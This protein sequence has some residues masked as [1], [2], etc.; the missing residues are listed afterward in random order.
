MLGEI[1]W[2]QY[3]IAFIIACHGISYIL[4]GIIVSSRLQGWKGGSWILGGRVSGDRLKS[5]VLVPH[6]AA[7]ALIIA[8]GVAIG[9]AASLPGWWR[10]VAIV[11][12]ALGLAGFAAFL[13][14]KPQLGVREGGIGAGI[15][16][17]LLVSAIVFA[18]AFR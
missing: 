4:F 1:P 17:I 16:A 8:C 9:L 18:G 2:L 7:G 14:G 6:V 12:A 15:S 11:G 13:A 5:V 3:L 10:P